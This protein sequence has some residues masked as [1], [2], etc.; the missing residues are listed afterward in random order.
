MIKR[1]ILRVQIWYA[2][3]TIAIMSIR[4]LLTIAKYIRSTLVTDDVVKI[5]FAKNLI[6][7]FE[8]DVVIYSKDGSL[9]TSTNFLHLS[10]KGKHEIDL[11]MAKEESANLNNNFKV[12]MTKHTP[13]YINNRNKETKEKEDI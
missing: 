10:P 6:L 13:M 7:D 3:L 9:I 5:T 8:K 11:I 12:M 1:Q 2:E 4:Q